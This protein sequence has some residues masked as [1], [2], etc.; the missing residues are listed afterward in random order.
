MVGDQT[1]GPAL[2]QL[3]Q[4]RAGAAVLRGG[5]GQSMI[6]RTKVCRGSPG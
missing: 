5:L 6:G 4:A 3:M 1:E 2:I